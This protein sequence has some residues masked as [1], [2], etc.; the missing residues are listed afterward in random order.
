MTEYMIY[1]TNDTEPFIVKTGEDLWTK[2]ELK[3][4][5]GKK[6]MWIIHEKETMYGHFQYDV[7]LN[8]DNI[9]SISTRKKVE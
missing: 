2:F 9:V 6:A 7:L 1:T 4:R 5:A 8:V 3:L